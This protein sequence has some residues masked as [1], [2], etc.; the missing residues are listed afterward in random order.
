MD[1]GALPPEIN[2]ARMYSGAGS[3][4]L[5]AAASAWDQLAAELH[6]AATMYQSVVSGLTTGVWTGPA[7]L[8]MASAAAPYVSWLSATASQAEETAAH[9]RAV[10]GAYETAFAATVPPAE[11][12]ANRSLLA[13]LVA[14]NF[15]G[16]NTPAI[17]AT[18]AHYAEM[19]AQDAAVMYSY[20]DASSAASTTV[21]PFATPPQT[22]NEDGSAL[23][24]D[25]VAKAAE[26]SQESSSSHLVS[27]AQQALQQLTSSSSSTSSSS[28]TS[29][30]DIWAKLQTYIKQLPGNLT[31]SE[32]IIQRL[33]STPANSG[34]IGK[35]LMG[36]PAPSSAAGVAKPVIPPA[37]TPA[38]AVPAGG[39]RGS[40]AASVGRAGTLG[41]LSVP[42]SWVSATPATSAEVTPLRV[43]T[44]DAAADQPRALLRGIPM[45][46]AGRRADGFVNRYGFRNT[47]IPRPP[48]AG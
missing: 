43:S 29:L 3:T 33:V 17:A 40:A 10:V 15:F 14:T 38:S 47:V 42:P 28:T 11:I 18:E 22:S 5:L 20:A 35:S 23:Q 46:G 25:A 32:Q 12:A 8:A 41:R 16:Q 36:S 19:W 48:F 1:F 45:S 13:A 24:Q 30:Q 37:S 9:A 2:S 4:P 7:S 31:K 6:T 26:S 27:S 39:L 44:I 34:G 21:T